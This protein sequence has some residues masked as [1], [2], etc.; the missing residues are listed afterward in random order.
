MEGDTYPAEGPAEG[1]VE[2][3]TYPV[4]GQ[5]HDTEMHDVEHIDEKG[6]SVMM[7][8]NVGDESEVKYLTPSKVEHRDPPRKKMRA[9]RL[10][11]P[12]V[13]T[14][15]TREQLK[16]T[17]PDPDMFDPIRPS[18]DEM[19]VKFSEYMAREEEE[20]E[21]NHLDYGFIVLDR[22]FFHVLL[23]SESWLTDDVRITL[24]THCPCVYL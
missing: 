17:L 6:K 18:P 4:E 23:K 24:I 15:E 19:V 13:V 8:D 11:S 10:M 5:T 9:Q 2:G 21:E 7:G 12:F 3:D 1:P 16:N 22:T 14:T 20:E